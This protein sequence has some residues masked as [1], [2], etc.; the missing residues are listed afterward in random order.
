MMKRV[1]NI[2]FMKNHPGIKIYKGYCVQ[3]KKKEE[4]LEQ[5]YIVPWEL[6][7]GDKT[8]VEH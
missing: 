8:K 4:S 6:T 5:H 7:Q 1:E 2:N 3:S